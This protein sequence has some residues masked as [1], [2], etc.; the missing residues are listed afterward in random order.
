MTAKTQDT[1]PICYGY[2]TDEGQSR[3]WICK[4][5]IEL[6]KASDGWPMTDGWGEDMAC[7]G[8]PAR[9]T[10]DDCAHA[11]ALAAQKAPT[12]ATNGWLWAQ[13]QALADRLGDVGDLGTSP[14][15]ALRK[16][17]HGKTYAFGSPEGVVTTILRTRRSEALHATMR[18]LLAYSTA[19]GDRRRGVGCS[20]YDVIEQ[21]LLGLL[22][23][24]LAPIAASLEGSLAT[25]HNGRR[26]GD[27]Q[28][29]DRIIWSLAGDIAGLHMRAIDR[30]RLRA[31]LAKARP[32]ASHA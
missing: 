31:A 19:H 26:V 30:V 7:I 25:M 32:G 23:R 3:T 22:T 10:C 4:P 21:A 17:G 13:A 24:D 2:E 28:D 9:A 27:H 16:L 18:D 5:C 14:A 15:A 8:G 20:I 12:E 11:R 6:R 1:R 29:M